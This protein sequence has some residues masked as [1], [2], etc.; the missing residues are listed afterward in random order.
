LLEAILIWVAAVASW[1]NRMYATEPSPEDV[2]LPDVV[3]T[4]AKPLIGV[5][6]NRLRSKMRD[7]FMI[8]P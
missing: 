7:F 6:A 4:F 8:N 1:S 5:S 2:M 3:M